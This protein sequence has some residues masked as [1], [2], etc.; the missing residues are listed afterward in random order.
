MHD[1][2]ALSYV[3]NYLNSV[4]R[5]T[6]EEDKADEHSDNN[7]KGGKPGEFRNVHRKGEPRRTDT[8]RK[9]SAR[10]DRAYFMGSYEV[11]EYVNRLAKEAGLGYQF[12]YRGTFGT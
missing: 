2:S 6:Q 9:H 11:F 4:G 3:L 5:K 8:Y 10:V 1:D 7:N 12:S